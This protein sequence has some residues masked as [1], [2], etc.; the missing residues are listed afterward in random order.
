MNQTRTEKLAKLA[1]VQGVGLQPGQIL[2][3][4]AHIEAAELARAIAKEAYDQQAREVI[5]RYSDEQITHETLTRASREAAQEIPEWQALFHNRTAEQGAAYIHIIGEDPDLMQDVDPQLM[6]QRAINSHKAMPEYRHRLDNLE[7]AWCIVAWP[8]ENWA[9]KVFPD[10]EHPQEKLLNDI[11]DLS[12]IDDVDPLENWNRH[13]ASFEKNSRILNGLQVREFH[14][15]NSLGTDLHVGMPEGYIFMGGNSVLKNGISTLPN[16]PTEEIFSAPHKDKVNG[17]VYASMPL[18]H[19]GSR[20]ENFWL[21]FRD[22]KVT[23]FDAQ[24]GKEVLA[25]ILDTDEGARRLGEIALVAKDTPVAE[26]H[27]IYYNTLIDENASCHFA[28]GSAY[29]DTIEN[30]LEMSP[31]ERQAKG[32]NDSDTHVDFMVGTPD[33]SILAILPDG[34]EVPVFENGKFSALFD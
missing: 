16:I 10:E 25:S 24:T 18:I 9:K 5:V 19:N 3:V 12:R 32:M 33:L 29:A 15:K 13:V 23:D 22:G 34:S 4:N 28:L 30:G 6:M 7:N 2:V 21:E 1:V 8:T 27:R 17:R 11:F 14:Y 20:I 26:K 31:E